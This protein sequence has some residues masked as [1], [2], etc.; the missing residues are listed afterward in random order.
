MESNI[1]INDVYYDLL[2]NNSRYLILYGSAGSGK[3]IFA[4]QKI[5]IRC[6]NEPGHRFLVTRK[7]AATIQNS[8]FK[9]FQDLIIQYNLSGLVKSNK[10]NLTFHFSNGSEI[11]TTG[12]DDV[13]K[14][15]SIQGIT[16]RWDEE[17]TEL[18][19]G[20]FDQLDLRL[21]G[22]TK[23]YKQDIITF[24]PID[25][26]HWFK[27]EF[28]D[29]KVDNC[30]IR[31][32]T[33]LDNKFIDQEYIDL[34]NSRIAGDENLYR[35]YVK[36][37]WGRIKTGAEFYS[38]FK[39]NKHVNSIQPPE[40]KI[41]HLSFDQNVVPYVS[42]LI[43]QVFQRDN[44]YI[45][46]CIDEMA[47]SNP[48]NKTECLC[49]DFLSRYPEA[50]RVFI[51][52]DASGKKRDT[53]NQYND[54]DIIEKKLHKLMSNTSNRVPVS[55]P[56]VT[57][58]RDFINRIFDDKYPIEIE[59]DP[60]CKKLIADLESVKEDIDGTKL[61]KK[62]LDKLTGQSYEPFGHCFVGETLI[63]TITGQ[64][65][66]DSLKVNDLVL[67]RNGYKCVLNVFDNGIREI[68]TYKI[69]DN[70]IKCTPDHK[71]YAN[72]QF[73]PIAHLIG[74]NTFTIFDK[75]RICKK[76]LLIIKVTT[77]LGIQKENQ[78]QKEYI[79]QGILRLMELIGKLGITFINGC[80]K[81]AKYLKVL[82]YIIKI[83]IHLIMKLVISSVLKI[84]IIANSICKTKEGKE[85]VQKCYSNTL[86]RRPLNGMD[87][88]QEENG[89]SNT[90]KTYL[91]LTKE[92]VKNVA[93]NTKGFLQIK[94]LSFIAVLNVKTGTIC[95]K[96]ENLVNGMKK[97]Y[98]LIVGLNLKHINSGKTNIA[99]GRVQDIQ[100]KVFDIEVEDCHEYFANNILVHN[101]SDAFDY[102]CVTIFRSYFDS[103][104]FIK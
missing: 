17:A 12:L 62:V 48:R 70:V 69:G 102:E 1:F 76:K 87:Q 3:S 103:M 26:N 85:R 77:S 50:E 74:L 79:I 44:K 22:E 94:L 46:R 5:L 98:A 67:T 33:Y 54:Y 21:R 25:E 86:N 82:L 39:F 41:Y 4:G 88:K 2:D 52:G 53:R 95:E 93:K 81:L 9:L 84:L 38:S 101:C 31:H 14:L 68:K 34:L 80:A 56:S 83:L 66:I 42:C 59:I 57:K 49:D 10:S 8:V 64:K 43:S 55:N 45:L 30:T 96:I 61:K 19:K 47:L 92:C 78:E 72:N 18:D 60:K 90:L 73:I 11:I 28:F 99:I 35:I 65:R 16:G 15:K 91:C 97:E 100:E 104:K 36:G 40:S 13:E 20:D 7:V 37:E 6:L 32:S 89:I 51:Y 27:A 24:N 58:R 29:K 75:K 71:I 23:Y 63:Q